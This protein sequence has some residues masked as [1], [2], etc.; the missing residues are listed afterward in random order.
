MNGV[1][2]N[3]H[4]VNTRASH[5]A[6]PFDRLIRERGA[7]PI[8][9]PCITIQPP[10]NTAELD[11][12][13]HQLILGKFDWLLLT[14]ANTV[15][16]L[17]QRLSTLELSLLEREMFRVGAIGAST[18]E[19]AKLELGLEVDLIPDDYIAESL[20]EALCQET[21]TSIFL[22]QSGIAPPTLANSLQAMGAVV[23][24]ITA[25]TTICGEG[26]VNLNDQLE[27]NDGDV[28][29][30]T[31]SS[32]VHCFIKRLH[33]EG[34]NEEMLEGVT[35]VCIG[36]KTAKTATSLG[37]DEVIVPQIFT[38][39]GMLDALE[40]HLVARGKAKI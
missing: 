3:K 9:Y 7:I 34:I 24:V 10:D 26:G 35:I 28:V 2:Y 32:T 30:F 14:S 1:L 5:Q 20:A 23:H 36:P 38:L 8:P 6:S 39:S 16:S 29:T 13:I 19:V 27:Q 25:Y 4:I 17:A 22:P 40:N 31:S 33:Q 11:A 15:H 37:F 21:G 18:A 12:A